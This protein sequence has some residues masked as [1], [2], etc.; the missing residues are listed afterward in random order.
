[1]LRSLYD[2]TLSL[3]A[4]RSAPFAL[5]AVS[6]LENFTVASILSRSGPAIRGVLDRHFNAMA[7]TGITALVGGFLPFP[8]L[9]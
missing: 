5:G 1:M 3:D 6:Y 4:R 7:A 8:Y 2:W 9:F